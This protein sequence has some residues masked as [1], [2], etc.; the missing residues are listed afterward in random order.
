MS[1]DRTPVTGPFRIHVDAR[2]A[3]VGI[4]VSHYLTAVVLGLAQAAD[5]D[6]HGLLDDLRYIAELARSAAHQGSDSHAAHER[7]ERVAD[8]LAEVA[9]DG[10][11][12]VYGEQVAR[13]RDRLAVLTAPRPVPG[14]R[15][16]GAA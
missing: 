1:A 11:I 13:L 5:E 16:A 12:P 9:D 14:Q 3:G 8:L 7:D 15:E 10:V 4:D 2:P 6:G